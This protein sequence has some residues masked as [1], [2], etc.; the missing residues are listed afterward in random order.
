MIVYLN[1]TL[2]GFFV[3][4][5]ARITGE[6]F[7]FVSDPFYASAN[8]L[9]ANI[10]INQ[11]TESRREK[12]VPQLSTE[13]R[14]SSQYFGKMRVPADYSLSFDITP[15]GLINDWGTIIHFSMD[16]QDIA[17]KGSRMPGYLFLT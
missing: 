3:F 13:F 2:A 5:S 11:L 12:M 1:G 7:M 16:G 15:L 6:A 14:L 8:A 10:K 4:P 9:I 17:T